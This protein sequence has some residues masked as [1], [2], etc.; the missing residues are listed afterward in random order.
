MYTELIAAL[1][2][3]GIYDN[4]TIIFTAD[5]GLAVKP[6]PCLLIKPANAHGELAISDVPVSMIE[7]YLPTLTYFITG[8]KDAGDTIYDLKSGMERDR[9]FYEYSFN[10]DG[11]YRTYDERTEKIYEAGAFSKNIK[12]GTELSPDDIALH[13]RR[14]FEDSG[15]TSIRATG[16][17]AALDFKIRE[18]YSDLQLDLDYETY[19]GSQTVRIYAN[20]TLVA[21]FE[22]NGNEEKSILI[23]GECVTDGNLR[24]RFSFPDAISPAELDPESR[25]IRKLALEFYSLKLSDAKNQ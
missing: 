6:N 2:K 15:H 5:H 4:T 10:S 13:N 21:D 19:N 8:E 14:G 16:K 3:A 25:N 24:L 18:E 9:K 1:K 22:A 7:D 17:E 12:L 20:D 23:P 11:R